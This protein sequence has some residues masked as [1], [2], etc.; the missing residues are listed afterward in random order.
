MGRGIKDRKSLFLRSC[1]STRNFKYTQI[2]NIKPILF[3]YSQIDVPVRSKS[4]NPS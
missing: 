2:K 1:I 4:Q 3:E